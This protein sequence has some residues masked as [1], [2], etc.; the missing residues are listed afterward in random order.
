MMSAL[1]DIAL[2]SLVASVIDN[3]ATAISSL[4]SVLYATYSILRLSN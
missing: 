3:H 2:Y 1:R 4:R